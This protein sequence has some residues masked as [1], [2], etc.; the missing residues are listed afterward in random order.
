MEVKIKS[1]MEMR[2]LF[3]VWQLWATIHMVSTRI[4]SWKGNGINEVDL[5]L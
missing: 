5:I 4:E 2:S 3:Y 1:R